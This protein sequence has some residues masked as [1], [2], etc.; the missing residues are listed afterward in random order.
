[1]S[2]RT[3]GLTTLAEFIPDSTGLSEVR[4]DGN[5]I[6]GSTYERGIK[7]YGV[8]EYDCDPSGFVA[9]LEAMKSSA[10]SKLSI[11]DCDIGPKGLMTL[12]PAM[13]DMAGLSEVRLDGNLIT[14]SKY[15]RI[16]KR[17]G[18]EEYD[19]DPSG[20]VALLEAMKS[21]AVL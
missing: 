2:S 8:E 7:R 6:T 20:F 1:M 4:L 17:L 13:S 21:S 15:K 12:A 5:P 3:S 16:N 11:A 18:V 10:V 14:G 9:L 19:C